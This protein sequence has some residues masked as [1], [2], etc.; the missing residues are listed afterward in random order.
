MEGRCDD[1]TIAKRRLRLALMCREVLR[2]A[3]T[4]LVLRRAVAR[5][6]ERAIDEA[7]QQCQHQSRTP[8]P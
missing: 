3:P 5:Q 4:A 7:Q 8:L 1:W 6:G 2:L